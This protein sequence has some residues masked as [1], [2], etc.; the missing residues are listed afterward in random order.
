VWCWGNN[1]YGQLGFGHLLSP[2]TSPAR[3]GTGTVLGVFASG[4]GNTTF[5]ITNE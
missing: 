4:E 3:V 1:S 5:T 2:Q